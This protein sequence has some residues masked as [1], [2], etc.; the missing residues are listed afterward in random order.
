VLWFG[1]ALAIVT[2][3]VVGLVPALRASRTDLAGSLKTGARDGGVRSSRTTTGLL[4]LQPALAVVLLVGA[5]LFVQSLRRVQSLDLGIETG[6]VLSINVRWPIMEM[7]SQD[8]AALERARRR[9]F[10]LDALE[11]L[12]TS[13]AVAG[14]SLA[15]GTP[16]E[17]S[18]GVRV[19]APGWDSLPRLAEGGPYITVVTSDY[20]A[21]VGTRL[22]RGRV[23]TPADRDGSERVVIVN[24]TMARTLWPAADALD[25]CLI[26]F[27]DTVPCAR[28]VGVVRDVHRFR[29]V[30][31]PSMQFY[32]PFGQEMQ[33]SGASLLVRPRDPVLARAAQTMRR[34][35]QQF[36]A[37]LPY[38]SIVP[39]QATVDPQM[40]SWRLGAFLF[41]LFGMLALGLASIG[42]YS[43]LAYLVEQ[44][45]YEFGVRSALGASAGAILGETMARGFAPAAAGLAIGVTIAMAVGRFVQP[46]LFETAARDPVVLGSVAALLLVV[47]IAATLLPARRATRVDPLVALRTE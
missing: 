31:A 41:T 15:I 22:V 37:G 23:F 28:V 42:L 38:L 45:T 4:I 13:A 3:I 7:P 32:I 34:E 24:E 36:R 44:R 8:A 12:R 43:V 6:R 40:R 39:L 47:A 25:Q 21:T 19:R 2:G 35:L 46:L 18:F 14:A 20:F 30:E 10:H 11:H 27:A 29:I 5:G 26:V 17:T 1:M 9:Q 16:F 33:I